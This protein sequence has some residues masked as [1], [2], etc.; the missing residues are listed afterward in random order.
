MPSFLLEQDLPENPFSLFSSWFEDAKASEIILVNAMTLSTVGLDG[1]PAS[2]TVLLKDVENEAF[3]FFTNY[4][5]QKGKELQKVPAAS[6]LFSWVPLERQV[7]IDGPVE[8]VSAAESDAYF[9]TRPRGSQLGA[10]A[11]P[12]S[13]IIADRTALD[14]AVEKAEY[15]YANHPVPRPPHWGGYRV[16]PDAIEFWQG[17]ASR[18]HDRIRYKKD[19]NSHW[20][21]ERLAP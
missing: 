11:S 13:E 9:A 20:I 7:R 8:K 19:R 3:V 15:Q 21:F 18:L 14:R 2:R 4:Q 1:K 6:L 17:Q 5:S 10:W 16:V 12:Q